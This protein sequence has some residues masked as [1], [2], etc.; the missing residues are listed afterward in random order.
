MVSLCSVLDTAS[1]AFTETHHP[2]NS[3]TGI[4]FPIPAPVCTALRAKELPRE[5]RVLCE[6]GHEPRAQ[7]SKQSQQFASHALSQQVMWDGGGEGEDTEMLLL[8]EA[9]LLQASSSFCRMLAPRI[10]E[11]QKGWEMTQLVAINCQPFSTCRSMLPKPLLLMVE[12]I[13]AVCKGE[14]PKPNPSLRGSPSRRASP[15]PF[16]SPAI[17]KETLAEQL[18]ERASW[19]LACKSHM[20]QEGWM[21]E[22]CQKPVGI[23]QA[24]VIW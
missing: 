16:Q 8:L 19:D 3:W 18:L 7:G 15:V 9:S 13:W 12:V 4:R 23:C 11:A 24:G 20:V 21:E 14:D 2:C 1:A 6:L 17:N 22:R 10:Y 5:R